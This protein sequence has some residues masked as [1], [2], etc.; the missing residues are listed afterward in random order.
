LR[1]KIPPYRRLDRRRLVPGRYVASCNAISWTWATGS[2]VLDGEGIGDNDQTAILLVSQRGY[3]GFDVLGAANSRDDR[4][5][6]HR[7]GGS[8]ECARVKCSSNHCRMRVH[9]DRNTTA[10]APSA[11]TMAAAATAGV[12]FEC[13]KR[14]NDE[15]HRSSVRADSKGAAGLAP[16]PARQLRRRGGKARRATASCGQR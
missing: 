12:C 5:H 14:H 2:M 6:C 16:Q 9:Q 13:E 15:Q 4:L 10:S 3:S 7:T 11:A 8:L 1:H